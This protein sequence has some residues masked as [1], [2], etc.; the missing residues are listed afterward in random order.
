M[1]LTAIL[2]IFSLKVIAD[3]KAVKDDDE[4]SKITMIYG[5][6]C[7]ATLGRFDFNVYD[8]RIKVDGREKL[9]VTLGRGGV[10]ID[11]QSTTFSIS[12]GKLKADIRKHL[13]SY[14]KKEEDI[15]TIRS[16]KWDS[17][18]GDMGAY[19]KLTVMLPSGDLAFKPSFFLIPFDDSPYRDIAK[20]VLDLLY[21]A[22]TDSGIK[23]EIDTIQRIQFFKK[24]FKMSPTREG[25]LEVYSL[26]HDVLAEIENL[27]RNGKIKIIDITRLSMGYTYGRGPLFDLYDMDYLKKIYK[28]NG[29]IVE[30][31]P[32]VAV[33]LYSGFSG[34]PL[35]DNNNIKAIRGIPN[36][37]FFYLNPDLL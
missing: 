20:Q 35:P 16:L 19:M 13:S 37:G 26:I 21:E 34:E 3:P 14:D 27:V 17:G 1:F 18:L 25:V 15:C 30:A 22:A 2:G 36:Y 10:C 24:P 5:Q 8:T 28:N 9:G 4:N 33:W 23:N 12:F 29:L 6:V 7:S 32:D 11:H 31:K